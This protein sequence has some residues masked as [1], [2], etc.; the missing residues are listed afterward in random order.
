M[1]K[2]PNYSQ[3]SRA[4]KVIATALQTTSRII[5]SIVI[6]NANTLSEA[7]LRT[8]RHGTDYLTNIRKSNIIPSV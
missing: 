6:G 3:F 8:I 1:T 5:G 2:N 4:I 7:L